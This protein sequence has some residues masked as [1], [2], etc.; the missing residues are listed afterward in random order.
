LSWGLTS[1]FKTYCLERLADSSQWGGTQVHSKHTWP[2]VYLAFAQ[3]SKEKL[4]LHKALLF[5]GDVLLSEQDADTAHHLFIVALDGFTSMDVHRSRAQ[6]MLRLGDIANGQGDISKAYE[7]WKGARPL[8]ERS[9][10]AKDVARID[11]R[12]FGVEEGPQNA[13]VHSTTSEVPVEEVRQFSLSADE[14][15]I[16]GLE[17]MVAEDVGRGRVAVGA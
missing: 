3:K 2:V 1:E 14:G 16:E 10:Q 8:F 4:A 12:L 17:D 11:T 13:L 6:C 5:L 9:S 7:L 15:S